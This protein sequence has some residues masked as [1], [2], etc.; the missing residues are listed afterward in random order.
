M[1]NT[2]RAGLT[3]LCLC[4]FAVAG[5][6]RVH[7]GGVIDTAIYP[8]QKHYRI[9]IEALADFT[10]PGIPDSERARFCFSS[11]LGTSVLDLKLQELIRREMKKLGFVEEC[12]AWTQV[13]YVSQ[14]S[15]RDY[16]TS[17]PDIFF[18]GQQVYSEREYYR[19]AIFQTST[20]KGYRSPSWLQKA[21]VPQLGHPD[22]DDIQMEGERAA[23]GQ[24][25]HSYIEL[26]NFFITHLS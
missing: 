1:S 4:I 14:V 25:N 7:L 24:D 21:N 11:K 12:P 18:G 5:C 15:H 9:W 26:R 16:I 20:I 3:L 6:K 19:H 22:Q 17:S 2:K 13:V 8:D 10:K 23:L